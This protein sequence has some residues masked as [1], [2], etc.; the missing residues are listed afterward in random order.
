MNTQRTNRHAATRSEGLTNVYVR[1]SREGPLLRM[2][3]HTV[4]QVLFGHFTNQEL[5]RGVS[6]AQNESQGTVIRP[7]G[8][9]LGA[10][11]DFRE[12]AVGRFESTL[13]PSRP[14]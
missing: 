4:M 3:Q 12:Y 5:S 11:G 6:E 1:A 7:I 13:H 8:F 14:W 2:H 9:V 10:V